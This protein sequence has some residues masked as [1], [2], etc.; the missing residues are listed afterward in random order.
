M[1]INADTIIRVVRQT[2]QAWICG[3]TGSYKTSLAYRLAYEFVLK[4]KYVRHIF[5]NNHS[6]WADNIENQVDQIDGVVIID[7]GGAYIEGKKEVTNFKWLAEKLNVIYLV[8]SNE[9]PPVNFRQVRIEPMWT[10]YDSGIPLIV[11]RWETKKGGKKDHGFF[12]WWKPSE[13]YGVYSRQDPGDDTTKLLQEVNRITR[14]FFEKFGRTN[15]PRKV[16]FAWWETVDKVAE[17]AEKALER[18]L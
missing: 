13:I 2:R 14:N 18:G 5:S 15:Q 6:V 10:I 11:Y 1:L 12:G 17:V 7:E 9:E 4:R 3:Y 16:D 8:P